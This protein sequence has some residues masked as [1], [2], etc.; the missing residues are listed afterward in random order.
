MHRENVQVYTSTAEQPQVMWVMPTL[1]RRVCPAWMGSTAGW[2]SS[3]LPLL[4]RMQFALPK[5]L[6]D[7]TLTYCN[8]VTSRHSGSPKIGTGEVREV[9]R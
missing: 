1:G 2:E 6:V 8:E 4:R 9:I 7:P 3:S 5:H